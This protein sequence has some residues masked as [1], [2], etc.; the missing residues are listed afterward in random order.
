MHVSESTKQMPGKGIRSS[1]AG[2]IGGCEAL[3]MG[4]WIYN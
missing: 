4:D 3:D 2:V 1:K